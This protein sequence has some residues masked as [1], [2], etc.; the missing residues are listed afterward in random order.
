MNLWSQIW[1]R[2][3]EWQTRDPENERSDK[4]KIKWL[5][6]VTECV[7]M[8]FEWC[9][10]R[11]EIERTNVDTLTQ[12]YLFFFNWLDTVTRT[13]QQS[14][15]INIRGQ[16]RNEK[17][18]NVRISLL[19]YH[20]DLALCHTSQSHISLREVWLLSVTFC[21]HDMVAGSAHWT[22]TARIFIVVVDLL[23]WRFFYPENPEI[24]IIPNNNK[25]QSKRKCFFFSCS[26]VVLSD[27]AVWI[28]IDWHNKSKAIE[29]CHLRI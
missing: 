7:S 26:S 25:T 5:F 1:W 10:R 8:C 18:K 15:S 20:S 12:F 23:L 9:A 29:Y 27:D 13:S 17:T 24:R 11:R 2:C 4:N 22:L 14:D 28:K 21:D 16:K 19:S 6:S 3:G